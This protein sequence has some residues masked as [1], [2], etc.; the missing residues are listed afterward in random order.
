M[1]FVFWLRR[2]LTLIRALCPSYCAI[3]SIQRL[4]DL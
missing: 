1:L 2:S 4:I 3:A